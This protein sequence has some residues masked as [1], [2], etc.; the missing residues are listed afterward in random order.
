MFRCLRTV[1]FFL[2][3][4]SLT[5]QQYVI[6]NSSLCNSTS[7]YNY[8]SFACTNCPSNTIKSFS[9]FCNCSAGYY[10]NE[11]VIGFQSSS[12]CLSM[13]STAN[14]TVKLIRNKD[15]SSSN[16]EIACASNSYS[17]SDRT[18]C[19]ACPLNMLY[20]STSNQCYCSSGININDKC[21]NT[22][23]IT[24]INMAMITFG[25]IN[26]LYPDPQYCQLLLDL[27]V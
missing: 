2:L 22:G 12:A 15:G 14:N 4:F 24:D 16:I 6:A 26:Q 23:T 7:Y 10:H 1:L 18:Q 11:A 5:Y 20:N 13:T 9:T 3:L 8:V 27:C 21:I 17:N 25:C 19:V